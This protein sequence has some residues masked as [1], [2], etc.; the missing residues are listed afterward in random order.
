MTVESTIN[1]VDIVAASGQ[2][3][4]AFSFKYFAA[5]DIQVF[6]DN[7][8]QTTG[9]TVNPS[10][11]GTD[12]GGSVVFASAPAE[13]S[14]VT[15]LRVLAITQTSDYEEG[16]N[17]PAQQVEDDFD[18]STMIN[19]QQEEAIRRRPALADTSL[20]TNVLIEDPTTP[21]IGHGLVWRQNTDLSWRLAPTVS[22]VDAAVAMLNQV[23]SDVEADRDRAEAAANAADTSAA[24]ALA[25]E[26]AAAASETNAG[27]IEATVIAQGNTQV[28][29]V[30]AEGNTQ[31]I[32]VETEGDTQVARV[33]SEGSSLVALTTQPAQAPSYSLLADVGTIAETVSRNSP[34][35]YVTPSGQLATAPENTLIP[36]YRDGRYGFEIFEA[37]TNVFQRSQEL[38][39]AYWTKSGATISANV[40]VA[41]DGTTTADLLTESTSN[42]NHRITN[43]SAPVQENTLQNFSVFLQAP[44]TN[45]RFFGRIR[46][47][48]NIGF[49]GETIFNLQDGTVQSPSATQGIEPLGNGIFRVWFTAEAQTGATT[50][51]NS[52]VYLWDTSSGGSGGG[53][54]YQGDGVSGVLVWGFQLEQGA[55]V[56]PYIPTTTA[57]VTRD[58]TNVN[59]YSN[60][61]FSID[62]GTLVCDFIYNDSQSASSLN[63]QT[64]FGLLT[65]DLNHAQIRQ[66]GVFFANFAGEITTIGHELNLIHGSKYRLAFTYNKSQMSSSLNGSDVSTGAFAPSSSI[67]GLII[68]RQRGNFRYANLNIENIVYYPVAVTDNEL[69]A[70]SAL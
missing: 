27:T 22:N 66:T 70:L 29:R 14:E 50:I 54:V 55:T 37:R 5:G 44:E 28:G 8:R 36:S 42:S 17:L 13:N 56:S 16:D 9:F 30:T 46:L 58:A 47:E 7:V 61:Y 38:D 34:Q 48:T 35:T 2:T 41:P 53:D 11:Q 63:W 32:R 51:N 26:Q 49:L 6:V 20:I 39:N 33:Q 65:P 19:Q 15:V 1:R 57:A 3:T 10:P 12:F 60:D 67:D 64:L 45:A 40:G 18:R 43:S 21:I 62:E 24:A 25:S 31:D 69:V 68:G 52:G 4:Y 23:V 59:L